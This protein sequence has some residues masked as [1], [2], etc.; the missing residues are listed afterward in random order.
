M[1]KDN[2]KSRLK[3]KMKKYRNMYRILYIFIL[4]TTGE[5]ERRC[6]CVLSVTDGDKSGRLLDR[7]SQSSQNWVRHTNTFSIF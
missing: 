7:G 1:C 4:G 3:K 2:A 6:G 5:W